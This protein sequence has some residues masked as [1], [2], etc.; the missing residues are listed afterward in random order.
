M[1]KPWPLHVISLILNTLLWYI[2][3]SVFSVFKSVFAMSLY[4]RQPKIP[5]LASVWT[6]VHRFTKS[7]GYPEVFF[8]FF[9]KIKNISIFCYSKF[10]FNTYLF[11]KYFYYIYPIF[12][13]KSLLTDSNVHW[14]SRV[15]PK[16]A[17][18]TNY[19]DKGITITRRYK[20]IM[21][22]S[23][24]FGNSCTLQEVQ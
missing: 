18:I 6:Q 17:K 16:G 24:D 23:A 3:I 9:C 10:K 11:V 22:I 7:C 14:L 4:R 1:F 8:Y 15:K 12:K 19:M 2:V 5:L 21:W 20:K 13:S